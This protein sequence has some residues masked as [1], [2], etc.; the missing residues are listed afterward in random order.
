VRTLLKKFNRIRFKL[1]ALVATVVFLTVSL[2][3][4]V[5]F[6][7]VREIIIDRTYEICSTLA[8]QL[9]AAA[10]EELLVNEVYDTT[11]TTLA[12]LNKEEILGL[13]NSYILNVNH[14]II[15]HT[16]TELVGQSAKEADVKYFEKIQALDLSEISQGRTILRFSFPVLIDYRGQTLRL[17]TVV[18]EFDKD[19]ILQPVATIRSLVFFIALALFAGS[20]LLTYFLSRRLSRPIVELSVAAGQL[21]EGNLGRQV[22]VRSL[23]E[24]GNLAMAFNSMSVSL[25][26]G[27]K[28]KIEKAALSREMDL[29]RN[30]QMSLLPPNGMVSC[31]EFLGGMETADE[32]GGDYLDC[33]HI[34]EGRS[35]YTWFFIG[36]VSGHGLRSGLI[37]LMAQTALHTL[38]ELNQTAVD[39]AFLT[40]NKILYDNIVRLSEFKYMTATLYRADPQGNFEYAGLHQD[41]CIFRQRTKKVETIPSRG[42]W[43]GIEEDIKS[44]TRRHRFRL[45]KGD[46]LFLYTDGIVETHSPEEEMFGHERLVEILEK[47]GQRPLAEIKEKLESTLVEFRGDSVLDD[48][49]TFALIRRK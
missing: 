27:E 5:V 8:N 29:A 14:T 21:A 7:Q 28:I 34:K 36:D 6:I 39:Q 16:S 49:I 19:E 47:N 22:S 1:I 46:L 20:L 18:F 42:M 43:L 4:A 3:S 45:E 10:T 23:D 35:D 15:A 41:I 31:Y 30:I 33:I 26:E 38:R 48:D 12:G 40:L 11:R 32:V 24:I 13:E 37:M 9:S 17:G 2:L 44:A 25:Q